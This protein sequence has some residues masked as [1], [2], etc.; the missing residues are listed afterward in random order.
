MKLLI[1]VLAVFLVAGLSSGS[2]ARTAVGTLEGTVVDMR[3]NAVAGATVTIQT[4]DGQHPHATHTNATGQFFFSG[5]ATGQYDLRAYFRGSYSDW[6]KRISIRA[7]KPTQITL[8]I[9]P[10]RVSSSRGQPTQY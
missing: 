4:S 6:S 10:S 7:H 8:R 9:S 5:F 3:G 2:N 1:S